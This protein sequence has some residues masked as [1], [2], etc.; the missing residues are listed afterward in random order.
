MPSSLITSPQ[1]NEDIAADTTFNITISMTNMELG[2]FTNAQL[3][4]YSA[5]T[6]LNGAGLVIGHTHITCQVTPHHPQKTNKLGPRRLIYPL[7]APRRVK[8]RLL[9]GNQQRRRWK[10]KRPSSSPQWFTSWLLPL[11]HPHFQRKS[12]PCTNARCAT[13]NTG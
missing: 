2:H 7:R 12:L 9:P 3:T 5:P 6:K 1:H 11:L 10:R 4:Y 13:W 8:I